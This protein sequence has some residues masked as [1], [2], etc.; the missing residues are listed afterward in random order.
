[1]RVEFGRHF[2]KRD[3]ER[4]FDGSFSLP[5]GF[6]FGCANAPFQVEG[7]FNGHGEPLNNWVEFER[8]GLAELSGEAIRFWTDYP[9]QLEMASRMG[10]NAFRIGIEWARVQPETSPTVQKEPAFDDGA[11]EAYAA[12]TA[13]VMEA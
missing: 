8:S 3:C 5:E 1:M 11:I 9:Q 12:M 7:G 4:L 2:S 13:A 6:M 10:L